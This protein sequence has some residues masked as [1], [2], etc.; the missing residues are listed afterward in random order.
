MLLLVGGGGYLCGFTLV[1]LLVVIA[2]I[3]I[4]IALLLPAV[5]AAREAARRMQCTNNLKQI[6]LAVH[7]FHD[8]RK[9]LPPS[10]V[11]YTGTT[12]Q[13]S[14]HHP[15]A[16]FWVLILPYFE[17]N[18]AYEILADKSNNFTGIMNNREFWNVLDPDPTRRLELQNS[19]CS[20]FKGFRCP[21]RRSGV[22]S[23]GDAPTDNGG[24]NNQ[25]GMYGPQGDYAFVQGRPYRHW[26]LWLNNYNPVAADH[27]PTQQGAIRVAS[28]T[29][30]NA[31][32]WQP[33][34]TMSWWADGTSN[35]LV[36]G[37]KHIRADLVGSCGANADAANRWRLG[38]CSMLITGDW[39]TLSSARSLNARLAR[40]PNDTH[41]DTNYGTEDKPHWGS[42]HTGTV[43]FLLGDGSVQAI[44]V[45]TP[46]GDLY[47]SEADANNKTDV[48]N[49]IIGRLGCARDGNTASI[50]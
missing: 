48:S 16:S 9:G 25:G 5:Q 18:A 26:A 28:W 42:S 27:A 30:G 35:Q 44:S 37:E 7:N 15:S 34:D 47:P 21:S 19:I 13:T 43:N 45:T 12:N 17:Q 20:S 41:A 40:G 50:P 6:G 10:T 11:G 46:S 23:L 4:L 38:D 8:A 31:G 3:G 49:S 32:S 33:R 14:A 39:N 29:G 22:V 1:E 2:I 36:V 24:T